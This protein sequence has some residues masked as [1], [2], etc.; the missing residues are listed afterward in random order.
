MREYKIFIKTKR[1]KKVWGFTLFRESLTL[2]EAVK[3]IERFR[4]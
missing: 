2:S 4:K 1:G 3:Y